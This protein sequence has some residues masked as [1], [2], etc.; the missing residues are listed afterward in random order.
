MYFQSLVGHFS[1]KAT[2]KMQPAVA[3]SASNANSFQRAK[4]F[5]P[6]VSPLPAPF[7]PRGEFGFQLKGGGGG[8]DRKEKKKEWDLFRIPRILQTCA[9]GEKKT[10]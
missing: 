2:K 1:Q 9:L 7:R 10:V 8:S 6:A 4:W 5:V 3:S